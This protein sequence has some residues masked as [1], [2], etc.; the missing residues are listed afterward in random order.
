MTL[1]RARVPA[2]VAVTWLCAGCPATGEEVRPP[3]DQFYFPTGMDDRRRTRTVLFVANANSDLRYDSG[4]VSVVD[5]DRVDAL[6]D[7][8]ARR[9]ASRPRG[10]TARS[11]S[12]V[13]YTLVCDEARGHPRPSAASAS[14]TSPPTSRSRRLEDGRRCAC[15]PRCAAIRRSPGSTTTARPPTCRAA[16]RGGF[17]ECDDDHRLI[18]L[19]NDDD[20]IGLP[21]EPFGLFVDSANGYVVVTHLSNGAAAVLARR[22]PGG[23]R[24]V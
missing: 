17:P 14:A 4:A 5:L 22:D 16:A 20:L 12:C 2:V 11:T 23:D 10:A 24:G 8:V 3:P 18:Q 15:S 9:P 6:V 21:D 7:D 13:P 1:C 19:R